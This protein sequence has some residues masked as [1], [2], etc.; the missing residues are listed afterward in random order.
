VI[1]LAEAQSHV[2]GRV[3]PLPPAECDISR[4]AGLVVAEAVVAREAVP[5]F[6]NSAMDGYAVRAADTEGATEEIP[7]RLFVAGEVAAG[8]V[9][10]GD[11]PPAGA[12]RI[13]TGAPIPPGA[14][15]VVMVERTRPDGDHVLVN[16]AAER[17]DHIRSAGDDVRP[18]DEVATLGEQLSPARLALL[19]SVGCATVACHPRPRVGVLSTGD[20][21]VDPGRALGP[22]QIRD[23]NRPMLLAIVEASGFAAVDLGHVGDDEAALV[24]HLE[25]AVGQC[26]AVITSGGVSVGAYDVVR[27]LL[28]RVGDVRWMQIAIK[29]AKPFLFGFLHGLPVFGLPGN[30]VSSAVSFE[31]LARPALRRMAG[32]PD[33][34]LH[35]PRRQAVTDVDLPRHSD[36]K[37]HFVRVVVAEGDDGRLHVRRPAGG[38]G[39]HQLSG[40]A[41]ATALAV[42]P[43][44]D[45]PTAGEEL[46][47]IVL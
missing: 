3:K 21:L 6:T 14:D 45:G 22:G 23:S 4:A 18:G 19:V 5:P 11:V 44:G 9:P 16:T 47:V 34:A 25:G 46:E 40:L 26:D 7:A 17:G 37:T 30:P 28:E 8:D 24:E 35:S 13:M 15:A 36:G 41:H 20:E 33:D 10:A 2:V 39:S 12:V 32:H 1:P 31:L 43:D 38:Q 42:V 29:P 27:N